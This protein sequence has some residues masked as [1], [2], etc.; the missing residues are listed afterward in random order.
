[1]VKNF[2]DNKAKE[3]VKKLILNAAAEK[4]LDLE[5][6][7]TNNIDEKLDVLMQAIIDD[8][9]YVKLI[10]MGIKIKWYIVNIKK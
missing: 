1:M 2:I 4:G 6:L 3:N 7:M 5:E 10:K 8:I 9:G